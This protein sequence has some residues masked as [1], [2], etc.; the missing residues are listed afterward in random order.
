MKVTVLPII[1]GAL[2]TALK[3]LEK[4]LAESEIRE[5]TKTI[6]TTAL[7]SWLDYLEEF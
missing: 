5:I 3:N 1:I 2:G 6:Q 4:R 7:L